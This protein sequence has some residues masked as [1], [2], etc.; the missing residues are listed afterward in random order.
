MGARA[1]FLGCHVK[2]SYKIDILITSLYPDTIKTNSRSSFSE[3]FE[4]FN[5]TVT[6]I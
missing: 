3:V 1:H 5:G 2:K 4:F 6:E